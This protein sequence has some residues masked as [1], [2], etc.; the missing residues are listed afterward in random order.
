MAPKAVS[1]TQLN[2]YIKRIIAADP[3]LCNIAVKGE[4]SGLT[5][6]SSG[7]WYFTIKDE[8]SRISCFLPFDRV[9]SLR[10]EISD[11]MEI[12]A[13]GNVSVYEKGGSYSL[14]IKDIEAQ[15]EGGLKQAFD[16][17]K[18][19]LEAEGLFD[20]AHKKPIPE[21]PKTIG[22]ITS[23]TGAAVRDIISTV[24][25]R[26]P[27][28]SVLLYPVLVQGAEAAQ[29]ISKAIDEMNRLFPALDVLIVGRGGGSIEDLWAFNEEAVARAIFRS[30]IPVISAVGHEV[31]YVISDFAADLRCETP[32]AAAERSVKHMGNYID[33]LEYCNPEI[34]YRSLK[35]K[36]SEKEYKLRMLKLALDSL[37]PQIG[38][39]RGYALVS[40][41]A[42]K[43]I[44]SAEE[45]EPGD[46]IMIRFTDGT[47]KAAAEEKLEKERT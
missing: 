34:L 40:N 31:D 12:T 46:K 18:K 15:G 24:K 41:E 36:L 25:R 2:N 1:V 9:R 11:G 39:S 22:I 7:H 38:L 47:V 32:T 23:P 30:E 33:K 3:I 28:V 8:F 42:G 43:Y 13:Y 44:S 29:D 21:D 5:K 17:L 35:N 19:K 26:N 37:N 45:I 14:Q 20:P 16:N 10:Y 6:H 27:T 4:I